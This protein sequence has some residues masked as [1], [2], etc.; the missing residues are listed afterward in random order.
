MYTEKYQAKTTQI[1]HIQNQHFTIGYGSLGMWNTVQNCR[2][3]GHA[4]D[5]IA[6]KVVLYTCGLLVNTAGRETD[7]TTNQDYTVQL[8][9]NPI[10]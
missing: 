6:L 5:Y 10:P 7:W 8:A 2:P 4:G 9:N 3:A 1:E